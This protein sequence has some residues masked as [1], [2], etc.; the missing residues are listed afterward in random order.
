MNFTAKLSIVCLTIG[1][2]ACATTNDPAKQQKIISQQQDYD[3][4]AFKPIYTDQ[5]GQIE[6]ILRQRNLTSSQE[7]K[8]ATENEL[9]LIERG[10]TAKASA[11]SGLLVIAS[12][13]SAVS[14]GY[15]PV[16]PSSGFSKEQLKGK[17]IE[18]HVKNPTLDYA[19]PIF[20]QW[21]KANASQLSP[22]QKPLQ[23]VSV[24]S[25]RFALIYEK[26]VGKEAYQLYNELHISFH[27]DWD[28]RKAFTHKCEMRSPA[29]ALPEWQANQYQAINQAVQSNLQQCIDDLDKNKARI[30]KALTPK[31]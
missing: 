3:K 21:I 14:G 23:K 6:L 13:A 7:K 1:L 24:E 9:V 15:V 16:H 19:R 11:L 27:N 31:A 20:N 5:I 26:L 4:T 2:T 30:I 18:P 22:T 28:N 17:K 12:V 29:K 8:L 25:N 10:N